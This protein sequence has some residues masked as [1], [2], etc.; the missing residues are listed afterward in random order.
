MNKHYIAFDIGGTYTKYAILTDSYEILLQDAF[1]TNIQNGVDMLFDKIVSTIQSQQLSYSLEGVAISSC[2]VIDTNHKCVRYANNNMPNY[3]H[4]NFLTKIEEK[5]GLPLSV[6]NDVF[7]F[8][9]SEQK[10]SNYL[11]FTIGTGIGGAIVISNKLYKGNNLTAGS[12]GQMQLFGRRFE[13][14]AS[15]KALLLKIHQMLPHITSLEQA[16]AQYTEDEKVKMILDAYFHVLATGILN[17]S[18]SFDPDVIYIGGGVAQNHFFLE[19]L[20]KNIETLKDSSYHHASL[21]QASFPNTGGL[22]GALVFFKQ[23][24]PK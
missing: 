21:Q 22:I 10:S 1:P 17:L 18:Y 3:T 11:F 6:E 4:A 19:Q 8:A 13:D 5:V 20:Q 24:Y 9:L 14:I 23:M 15:S 7:C 12:F 16:F 2:G